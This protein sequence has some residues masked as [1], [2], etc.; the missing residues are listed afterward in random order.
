MLSDNLFAIRLRFAVG[1]SVILLFFPKYYNLNGK[2]PH[3][4]YE[5][6][7]PRSPEPR[8]AP[9]LAAAPEAIR[10]SILVAM[11][12]QDLDHG[13]NDTSMEFFYKDNEIDGGEGRG[14]GNHTAP[15]MTNKGSPAVDL[16]SAEHVVWELQTPLNLS[17]LPGVLLFRPVN[18]VFR[19]NVKHKLDDREGLTEFGESQFERMPHLP[20]RF[21]P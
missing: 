20:P 1:V 4:T 16:D 18:K 5:Y 6:T 19:N 11:P 8:P 3:I 7:V 13:L 2:M 21:Q 17:N 15:V 10:K 9:P 14:P 12:S